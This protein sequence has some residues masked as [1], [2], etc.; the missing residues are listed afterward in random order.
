[1]ENNVA[2]HI[3]RRVF[4]STSELEGLLGLLKDHCGPDEYKTYARAVA[5]AIHGINSE[6]LNRVLSSHPQLADE[7][8]ADIAKFGRF[9]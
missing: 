1:M 3:V 7:I 5:S 8:E 2:R 9:L 4:R 6:L